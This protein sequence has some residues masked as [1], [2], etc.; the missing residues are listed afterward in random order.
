MPAKKKVKRLK[1]VSNKPEWIQ[2]KDGTFTLIIETKKPIAAQNS[3][4]FEN[5]NNKVISE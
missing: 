3:N 5:N 4:N 1:N 2:S